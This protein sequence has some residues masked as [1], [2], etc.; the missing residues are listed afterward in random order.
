MISNKLYCLFPE[1]PWT[2]ESFKLWNSFVKYLEKKFP[3]VA[4]QEIACCYP[5]SCLQN[6]TF[7][8]ANS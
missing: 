2:S 5:A 4:P 6:T 8:G 1:D 7:L 3:L